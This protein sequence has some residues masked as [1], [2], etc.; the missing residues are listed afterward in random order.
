[1]A[2]YCVEADINRVLSSGGV[3]AFADHDESGTSDAGVV[4]DCIVR[5]SEEIN[6]YCRQRYSEAGLL[7]SSL[8]TRWATILAACFVCEL[9]GN[10]VPASLAKEADRLLEEI[11]P[12]ILAGKMNLP[13]IAYANDLRPA[14]SNLTV[15]RRWRFSKIR[16]TGPNSTNVASKVERKDVFDIILPSN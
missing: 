1:M 2:T 4:D 16:R 13:G 3:I 12:N 15:D 14:V 10:P 5:A 9:R 11:L 8:V 6:L 7:T